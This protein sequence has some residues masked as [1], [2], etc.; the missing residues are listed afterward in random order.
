MLANSCIYIDEKRISRRHSIPHG[1]RFELNP[2]NIKVLNSA[3][4]NKKAIALSGD[5]LTNLRYYALL[6]SQASDRYLKNYPLP[7]RLVF[8]TN[9]LREKDSIAVVRSTID[10]E[11]KIT[12]QIQDDFWQ[13]N[14]LCDEILNTHNWLSLQVLSQLSLKT[15]NYLG[16][17]SWIVSLIATCTTV[18]IIFYFF[19]VNYLTKILLVVFS[20]IVLK[21]IA[22]Y[23]L[24]KKLKSW[25]L[26]RLLFGFLGANL[27]NRRL[28]F[29][30]LSILG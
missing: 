23:L 4:K 14:E 25:I 5:L 7:S 29:Q 3:R 20:S 18:S 30:I 6:S 24:K 15:K 11:G 2:K 27:K 9:Y 10:I 12:Q 26:D 28:A 19:S 1:I 16:F 13:N 22:E 21:K 8:T 17:S